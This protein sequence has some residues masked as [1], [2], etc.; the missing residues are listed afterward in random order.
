MPNYAGVSRRRRSSGNQWVEALEISSALI[1]LMVLVAWLEYLLP[2]LR[3]FG[4]VPRTLRGLVGILFSPLL[5]L[6]FAH[7]TANAASLWV[8]LVLLFGSSHHAPERTL[9]WIWLGS[10]LGTW[11]IGR[12][13]AVHIGASSLIYGLVVY[14]LAAGWW[15]RTWRAALVALF[16]LLIYGGIFYGVLPQRGTVSWEGHLAGAISGLLVARRKSSR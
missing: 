11:L 14:F 10:G 2:G 4:I 3:G 6:N 9:G 8:L 16:V 13:D 7:L 12:G 1:A 5:H 15:L